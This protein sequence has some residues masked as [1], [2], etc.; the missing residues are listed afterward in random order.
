MTNIGKKLGHDGLKNVSGGTGAAT[1]IKAVGNAVR[2]AGLQSVCPK[3]GASSLIAQ[4][5]SEDNGRTA[6]E[7]KECTSC[8]AAMIYGDNIM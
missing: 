1:A 5:F 7:G 8:G 3:C 6:Y 4:R 2:V